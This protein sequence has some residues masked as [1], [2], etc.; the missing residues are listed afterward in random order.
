[1]PEQLKATFR[2][3]TPMFLGDAMQRATSL[4]P[5]AIKGAIRFWWRA[6]QW[7]GCLK[8][9]SGD[10]TGALRLLHE[11]EGELF[12]AASGSRGASQSLFLLQAELRDGNYETVP[13]GRTSP[14]HSYLL[15]QGLYHFSKGYQRKAISAGAQ[16]SLRLT[17]RK[18]TTGAQRRELQEALYLWGCL[19]GLGS[20]SR[21]GLGSVSIETLA[22]FD[23][24]VPGNPAALGR[25]L[26][27]LLPDLPPDPPPYTAFSKLSRLSC[28]MVAN[29]PWLLLGKVGLEMMMYRSWGRNGRVAGQPA[30]RNFPGDYNSVSSALKGTC[31]QSLPTRI[32]F[33]LPHNYYFASAGQGVSVEPQHKDRK[34][35]ASP[36]LIHV[37]RFPDGSHA[38]VQS[39]LPAWFLPPGDVVEMGSRA[40]RAPCRLSADPPYKVIH[41]YL[42]RFNDRKELLP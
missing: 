24:S 41:T 8:Q 25:S 39:L 20:R 12:G 11:R 38:A 26:K 14:G 27:E 7:A 35:R 2:V 31:P 40:L 30:E 6:R 28:S 15:G 36:L 1:M 18:Q 29:D 22:G 13:K 32:A 16:I 17:L 4:R 9:T 23:L 37:H 19:G 10:S 42:N 21:R 3:T 34:R 33:G 5:P